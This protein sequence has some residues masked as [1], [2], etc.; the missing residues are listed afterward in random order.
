MTNLPKTNF[1]L[2]TED[3]D[4]ASE[5]LTREMGFE[6]DF[7]FP[8]DNPRAVGFS[9]NGFKVVVRLA[10]E[11][12]LDGN[13]DLKAV[14]DWLP[15]LDPGDSTAEVLKE[16]SVEFLI[17]DAAEGDG[18]TGRAGMSYRDLLPGRLG[19]L[20]IAS[21]ISIP[22]DGPVPDYVHFHRVDFQLIYCLKGRVLLVYEDQGDPFWLEAGDCVLQPTGIRHRVLE[23]IGG[24]EV[25]EVSSPAEHL[26][27]AEK[28]LELPN[29]K[30]RLERKF[31][32]QSF[33][34]SLAREAVWEDFDEIGSRRETGIG[35]DS[36][37]GFTVSVF[38]LKL[39]AVAGFPCGDSDRF[40]YLSK[41]EIEL[42][43][44]NDIRK[45]QTGDAF[46]V[47]KQ[48]PLEYRVEWGECEVV[49]V[50]F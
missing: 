15:G 6:L 35:S 31:G 14:D 29:E 45:L 16:G 24:L 25:L 44:G 1:T 5:R 43:F 37:V 11:G 8:A 4:S 39:G 9:R 47:S 50:L 18:I 20:L 21:H 23:A 41:G 2:W 22:E 26:T 34:R 19:G 42:D 32:G 7:V 13:F 12:S 46:F 40:C 38:R 17:S 49:A 33:A 27:F 28:T 36:G 30:K 3:I 48:A 10:P